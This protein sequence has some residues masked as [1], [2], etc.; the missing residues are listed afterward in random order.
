MTKLSKCTPVVVDFKYVFINYTLL[1]LFSQLTI[2][3]G[4]DIQI[5]QIDKEIVTFS[6]CTLEFC[7]IFS[8][9]Y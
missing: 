6:V 7:N 8:S 3:T 9:T 1:K 2:V 5:T 4:I